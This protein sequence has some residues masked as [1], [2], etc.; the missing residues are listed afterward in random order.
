M[1]IVFLQNLFLTEAAD[2]KKKLSKLIFLFLLT[3]IAV[4]GGFATHASAAVKELKITS[5]PADAVVY[6]GDSAKLSVTTTGGGTLN[7]QWYRNTVNTTSSGFKVVGATRSSYIPPTADIGT[8][9][10]FCKI[11]STG[12]SIST[13]TSAAAAVTVK[14]LPQITSQPTGASV[15]SGQS[16]I[17]STAASGSGA[18]TY[19]WYSNTSKSESN[20]VMIQGAATPSYTAPSSSAG[21]LYY[22]CVVTNTDGTITAAQTKSV[23]SNIVKVTVTA[24]SGTAPLIISQP[25]SVI[26]YAET[27]AQVSVTAVASGTLSYKWYS[28]TS[29]ST[30][31]GAAITDATGPSHTVPTGSTGTMYYYCVVTNTAGGAEYQ[32]V[33]TVIPCTVV[34]QTAITV[35]PAGKTANVGDSVPL[36]VTATGSGTLTYQWYKTTGGSYSS[37]KIPGATGASYIVPT[38]STGTANYYCV[39]T[40]T[41]STITG[42]VKTSTATS[43]SVQVVILVETVTAPTITAQPVSSVVYAGTLKSIS[44]T[45]AGTGVL[46][47]Q[48]YSNTSDATDTGAPISGATNAT[49]A[50]APGAAGTV[51]YY[52]IVKN[53][54]N[55][56]SGQQSATSASTSASVTAVA[57]PVIGEQPA[58]ASLCA[59]SQAT[60]TL[61]ATGSGTLSYQWYTC[62]DTKAAGAKITGATAASYVVQMKTLGVSYFYCIVTNTDSRIT[63]TVKTAAVS[64]SPAK[65]TVL[66]ADAELP[67]ITKQPSGVNVVTGV[68]STLSVAAA[69]SGTLSYQWFS[70]TKQSVAGATPIDGATSASYVP[71]TGAV[72]RVYYYCSVTNTDLTK[73]RTRSRSVITSVVSV[74]VNSREPAVTKQPASAVIYAGSTFSLSVT[75]AGCGTLSY[76]WYSNS[77]DL[78]SGGTPIDGAVSAKLT[79]PSGTVGTVYYYCVVTNTVIAATGNVSGSAVSEAC[80]IDVTA[81]P[82]FTLQPAD[83]TLTGGESVTLTVDV[84]GNGVITYQ[85]YMTNGP[86]ASGTPVRKAT[87]PSFTLTTA[88]T[89]ATNTVYYYCLVTVTD[90]SITQTPRVTLK[91]TAAAVTIKA[92]NAAPPTITKKPV[93]RNLRIGDSAAVSVTASGS[94]VLT[95]QWYVNTKNS[96]AGA[97]LIASATGATLSIP[98][99]AAGTRYYFCVVTNTDN[100]LKGT[101]T[102]SAASAIA[103]IIIKG[104]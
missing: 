10:F 18:L 61:G 1:L 8:A 90:K 86:T 29:N 23:R 47:Y 54:A 26:V 42:S 4:A 17:L 62:K 67:V 48:W 98:T 58:D 21:T 36:S 70:N 97:T 52:C 91:S 55:T 92:A 35:Q 19:Q 39:V 65:V 3:G 15:Y 2:M 101:K 81:Y 94:G 53:T 82:S 13:V 96:T 41:D 28:S 87:A 16:V 103:R 66:S 38:T 5:Q 77:S 51:W 78:N 56:N 24:L 60:L 85:W 25:S 46:S 11:Y 37:S 12:V 93:S 40:G 43:A 79:V 45:A 74:L 84:S 102:A 59:G 100:T 32:T 30:S 72:G 104:S 7:Y 14:A 34:A 44:V 22:Y 57:L 68:Q 33:S 88:A 20:A 9:Y 80:Y 83:T 99:S 75:A 49:Y 63:E 69:G 95:Y 76:Q 89:K 71:P 6:A 31:A 73:T 50:V 27:S 64:S